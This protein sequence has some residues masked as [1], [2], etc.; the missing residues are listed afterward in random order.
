[1][2]P[3][4]R[5]TAPLLMGLAAGAIT[6]QGGMDVWGEQP[7]RVGFSVRP[8]FNIKASFSNLGGAPPNTEIGAAVGGQNHYY[9]DGYN[10]LDSQQNPGGTTFYWGYDSPS[11]AQDGGIVMSS[12]YAEPL[13]ELTE[14]SDDPHWGGE[15][16]YMRELGWNNSYWY[17]LVVG[18][19]WHDLRFSQS[20]SFTYD[21][22]RISDAYVLPGELPPA[23]FRGRP[24]DTVES[25]GYELGDTPTRT[26]APVS[27][28]AQTSGNYD[29]RASAYILRTGLLFETPFTDSLDLQFG[30]GVVGAM[31][32]GRFSFRETTLVTSMDPYAASGAESSTSFAGGGYAEVN[33][34]LRV[35]K[36]TYAFAGAQYLMLTDMSQSVGSRK[37]EL[38][39]KNGIV[40]SFGMNFAF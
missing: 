22:L 24:D 6:V 21:A 25:G 29:Y 17:G 32:D 23:P 1:M 40:A 15:L 35:A 14:V 16:T 34:S 26:S 12:T 27:N 20:Q 13:G 7:N 33:L 2:D 28:G 11:Q 18:L 36:G 31:V 9:D 38:D 39:S 8:L 19:S 4:I 30:G 37:V 5:R 3:T 10:L